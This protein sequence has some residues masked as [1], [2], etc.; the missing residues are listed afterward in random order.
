MTLFLRTPGG[1]E[2]LS[3][4]LVNLE[5]IRESLHCLLK[6]REIVT[7][8]LFLRTPGGA[9]ALSDRLLDLVVTL[10]FR[11]ADALDTIILIQSNKLLR[12]R[13]SK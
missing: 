8:T 13:R 2:A 9:E 12:R 4:I 6:M 7:M 3:D 1:A 11:L 5:A 10:A